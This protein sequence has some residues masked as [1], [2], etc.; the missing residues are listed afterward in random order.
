[1]SIV[2]SIARIAIVSLAIAGLAGPS[3]AAEPKQGGTLV[4][5]AGAGVRHLNPA[6]QSGGATGVPGTQIFAGLV[7][8]DDKFVP[9]PYLAK[10]WEVSD[11]GMSYTFHLVENA[12]FHDGE[13]ITSEDVAFSLATV[14]ANHP[15]GIAMFDAVDR[16]D[17][18]DPHTAVIRLKKPHPAL[19]QA[20]APL[21]MP[22]I[23]KHVFGDGQE[24]KTHP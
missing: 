17:T 13:P 11:D 8:I 20:L 16:V 14:K 4:V 10:S 7:R 12:R 5:G 2:R 3:Y 18:P 6:V 24:P 9:H 23:P 22:V 15:F 1:M 19:M 21:L